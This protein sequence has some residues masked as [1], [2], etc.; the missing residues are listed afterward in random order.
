MEVQPRNVSAM[1]P[2]RQNLPQRNLKSTKN[3]CNNHL[4]SPPPPQV[5][6]GFLHLSPWITYTQDMRKAIHP[7]LQVGP[8]VTQ[9]TRSPS[10]SHMTS[11]GSRR[12]CNVG[13]SRARDGKSNFMQ[14]LSLP[15]GL[16]RNS[17]NSG[18]RILGFKYQLLH[19]QSGIELPWGG[20]SLLSPGPVTE[21]S[22]SVLPHLYMGSSSSHLTRQL[23]GGKET[24]S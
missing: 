17:I 9:L 16:K 1:D 6:N 21:T 7:I 24:I 3:L 22:G 4:S 2:G 11:Q 23:G 14:C 18:P 8:K 13:A 20:G 12:P 5:W 10:T 19:L 15:K